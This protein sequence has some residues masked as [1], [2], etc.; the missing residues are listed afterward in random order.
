MFFL[1]SVLALTSLSPARAAD[2]RP[3][4]LWVTI[5]DTSPEFIGSYGNRN[6]K[7]PVMDRLAAEGYRFTNAFSTGSVCSPSRT[8]LITAVKTYEAGTGHHRSKVPLPSFVKGFPYYLRQAGY[9]TANNKKTDYN[10]AGEKNFIGEAWNECDAAAD[11]S[12]RRPGQPF[13][14]VFNFED[15]HQSRTMTLP[16]ARYQKQVLDQLEPAIRTPDEG[17]DVPPFYRDSPAMRKQLARVY[18]SITLTDQKIGRL[19]QRLENEGLRENTII[20]FFADH[21]EGIPRGKT[22][23][24]DLSYRVPLVVWF[25]PKYRHLSPWGQPGSTVQELVDFQDFGPSILSLAGAEIPGQMKGRAFLGKARK[26]PPPYCFLSSDRSDNSTDLARTVTDGRLVYTRNFMPFLPEVR[27]IRY[28]EIGE[29][30]QEMRKDLRDGKLD[31][32]QASLFAARPPE[33][34][35]DLSRDPWE[36]KNL[37]EDPAYRSVKEKMRAALQKELQQARDVMFLPEYSISGL[38]DGTTPYEFRKDAKKYP[39][40]RILQAANLSGFT[41]QKSLKAQI[42]LL[43]EADSVRRYW[44]LMSLCSYR[45]GGLEIYRPQLE[46]ALQDTYPPAAVLAAWLCYHHWG[47][48]AARENLVSFIRSENQ[49]I[50]LLA[51]NM[52]LYTP[53]RSVF[54]G[55]VEEAYQKTERFKVPYNVKAA[56]RDFLGSLGLI[57]NTFENAE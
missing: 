27:Y 45:K 48:P 2:D 24:I 41:D 14:A 29:I 50:A 39:A 34:L 51:L 35:Y 17:F 21:G 22:N 12:H 36:L 37:A 38:P 28:M 31:A 25:P 8:A 42:K 46:A 32:V 11:W 54:V 26:T 18:N 3:N 20:W 55:A 23:S 1:F 15:S 44:G 47:R 49:D 40:D 53:E 6:A 7:T 52:L 57:A 4:I 9:F 19:L 13:F 56:C 10:I 5:E 33:M 16:Y 43:G 30:K